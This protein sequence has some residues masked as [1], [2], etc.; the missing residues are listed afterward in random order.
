MEGDLA[1][2]RQLID[3]AQLQDKS[4]LRTRARESLLAVDLLLRVRS[5]NGNVSRQLVAKLRDLHLVTRG[6]GVR[7]F[8]TGALLSGLLHIGQLDDARR[9]CDD[10]FGVRRT[11]LRTH[12]VL[13]EARHA[14]ERR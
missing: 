7:D 2:A 4:I 14:L 10:Y 1:R 8:E 12:S 13:T 3:H 11:R 5:R 6:C 9:L